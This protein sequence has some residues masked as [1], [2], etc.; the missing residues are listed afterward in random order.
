MREYQS[1][2]TEIDGNVG[3][4]TLN[5]A[6][7]HNAFD[8]QL[9]AEITAGLR[10]F[11]ADPRVRAVVLSS[12]G[13]S[14]C[15]GAD[16]HWM[17][18]A[19]DYGAE[20]NLRDAHRLATLLSTLNDLAKPTIARV[21]GAAY[22]GGVGLVAACDIAVG[23]YDAV[24]TLSEVKLGIVPA[25]ISPYVLAAIGE[26]YCRRYMLTAERFSAAEAYRIGLL[27]ELVPGEEQ[28]DEAIAEILESLLANG[29][30]A[31]AECKEL[32]RVVTGQ[33]ID[34]QTIEETVQRITRVRASPEG[35]EGLAAFLEK[36]S[37]NWLRE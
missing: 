28:L 4:L 17:Q 26:R 3:I 24:F 21:Q 27:H 36:R 37:P 23:T 12:T 35:R 9:I 32:I 22:G 5:K 7:R 18:R 29:P 6:K 14:F 15:A 25:V 16:V 13:K 20:E 34:A 33:P 8:E 31:Q 1:I 19:A 11:E 30:Q 10:E 2:V